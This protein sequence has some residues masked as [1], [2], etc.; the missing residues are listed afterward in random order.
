MDRCFTDKP[1]TI[2]TECFLSSIYENSDN[3]ITIT[4]ILERFKE[5]L[6]FYENMFTKRN[7]KEILNNV[8]GWLEDI[9]NAQLRLIIKMPDKVIEE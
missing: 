8:N 5:L 4:K 7:Y 6:N 9:A 3:I 2:I 1:E